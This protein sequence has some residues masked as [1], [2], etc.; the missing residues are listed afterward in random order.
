MSVH[1]RAKS[2]YMSLGDRLR[3]N[4]L[5]DAK[6]LVEQEV[7]TWK[8]WVDLPVR[9][10]LWL[11]R[12]GFTSPCGVLYDFDTYGPEAYIS[13]LERHRL[14]RAINGDH[15]YLVD[16][17]LSQH[18]MLADHPE[19]R[20]TAFGL[21]D[22]GAVH[23]LAGTAFDGDP[24]PVPEW[25]PSTLRRESRLVLKQLRGGGGSEV[26]LCESDD[27]GGFLLDGEPVRER[28]LVAAFEDLAGYL[29]SAFV[30][31]HEYADALY[32][33]ATN[34]LRVVTLWDDANDR[35]RVP[36]AVQRI[37]TADSRPVDNFSSGGLSAGVDVETGEL[38]AAVRHPGV[39]ER[40]WHDRHP[41]TGAPI[42]GERV[43]Q[44]DAVRETIVR[45]ARDHT[46]FPLLGWDVVVD[47][48]GTP[49]VIEANTG[50]DVDLIQAHGPL[51]E[52]PDVA[53]VVSRYLPEVDRPSVPSRSRERTVQSDG[54]Q[55]RRH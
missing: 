14:F 12:H 50:T 34:T 1:G 47:E 35:L 2:A 32:P 25:L 54:R 21:V 29:V 22:G 52:D 55:I 26:H 28:E 48:T 27:E 33:H 36:A 5:M 46:A 53:A 23:G 38:S 19:H 10:R 51:L 37:G 30:H 42:A 43:P 7:D 11:W 6:W 9:R 15:R 41:D 18:W 31:Q 8:G 4:A 16:D 40:L 3:N 44:W 17:K 20:P 24:V 13:E 49:V 39:S 45:I